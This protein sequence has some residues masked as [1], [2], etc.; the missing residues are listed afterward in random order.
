VKLTFQHSDGALAQPEKVDENLYDPSRVS[1]KSLEVINGHL[2]YENV[3]YNSS[4]ESIPLNAIRRGALFRGKMVGSTLNADYTIEDY[5]SMTT[6]QYCVKKEDDWKRVE[7]I[8]GAGIEVYVPHTGTLMLT[9]QVGYE[10]DLD[11]TMNPDAPAVSKNQPYFYQQRSFLTLMGA[12]GDN[13][14][15]E[16]GHRHYFP[17]S[18]DKEGNNTEIHVG[19]HRMWSGHHIIKCASDTWYRFSIGIFST[20]NLARVR[21]RNF[22]Y[23]YFPNATPQL[24]GQKGEGGPP[25]SDTLGLRHGTGEDAL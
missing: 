6:A 23:L 2:D 17:W 13:R 3:D 19:R 4:N 18:V 21:T 15:T 7:A 22:K 20:A 11:R 5:D 10:A 9:W 16:I 1:G 25:V 14:I 12:I 8:P 24:T